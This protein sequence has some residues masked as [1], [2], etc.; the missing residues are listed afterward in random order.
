MR[1]DT[2]IDRRWFLKTAS[3]GSGV[4]LFQPFASGADEAGAVVRFGLVADVHQDIMHDSCERITA[5]ADAMNKA[6]PDFICQLGDFCQPRQRN[7]P[8]LAQWNRFKGA[9]YHVIGNHEMDGGFSCEQVA[10][11]FGM[12]SRYYSFDVGGIHVMVLDG[13]DPGGKARGYKRYIA[14]KQLGWIAADLRAT[15][16]PTVVL[17]HQTL[18]DSGGVENSPVVRGI[19]EAAKAPSGRSK[20]VA[21]F[22]GHHNDDR[23]R[24]INGLHY[25]HINSASY[26]WLGRKFSH[27][28]YAKEIHRKH[29]L[30]SCTAPYKD[31][32]WALVEIDPARGRIVVKGRKTR[33]VGPDPWALGAG[34]M[35]LTPKAVDPRISGRSLAFGNTR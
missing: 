25:I 7:R 16:L 19:L 15:S 23:A 3:L 4:F 24:V 26:K 27:E 2:T 10:G 12:K 29:R 34:A 1:Q 11:F 20:V 32:L 30:I 8:F 31:P 33:W 28:S 18:G 13:N 9:R 6:R 5:F 17:S 14:A 35:M 21:C 22:C